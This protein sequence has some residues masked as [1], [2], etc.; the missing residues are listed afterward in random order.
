VILGGMGSLPGAVIG[1]LIVGM[2]ESFVTTYVGA[3]L[4]MMVVFLVM[5]GVFLLKPAG[6]L[7]HEE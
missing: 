2:G 6:I 7:G 4:A 3:H 5:I 1:G